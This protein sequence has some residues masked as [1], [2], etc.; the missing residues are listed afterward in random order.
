MIR[1]SL[2]TEY[3]NLFSPENQLR[4]SDKKNFPELKAAWSRGAGVLTGG[5]RKA[6]RRKA[7]EDRRAQER[8][9]GEGRGK[10]PE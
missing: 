5:P 10:G 6:G 1:S 8:N 7:L 3:L 9:C 2:F 4:N